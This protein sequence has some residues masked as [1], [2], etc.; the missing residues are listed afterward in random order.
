MYK[1]SSEL[2]GKTRHKFYEWL[3]PTRPTKIKLT[4]HTVY[5]YASKP[6]QIH[7]NTRHLCYNT[8]IISIESASF[9]EV[10]LQTIGETLHILRNLFS[11]P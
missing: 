5:I 2:L 9:S 4:S 7:L 11:I 8:G 3:V 1:Y 6:P 10:F